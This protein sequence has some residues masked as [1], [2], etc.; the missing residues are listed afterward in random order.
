MKTDSNK[1]HHKQNSKIEKL[2]KLFPEQ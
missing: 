2:M 1:H